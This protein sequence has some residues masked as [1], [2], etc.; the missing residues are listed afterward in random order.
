MMINM[1]PER[2]RQVLRSRSSLFALL[3]FLGVLP[4]LM[5]PMLL[6]DPQATRNPA[7]IL[8]ALCIGTFP[9]S[10]FISVLVSWP[11]YRHERYAA[12]TWV[13]ILPVANLLL[14]GMVVG[15]WKFV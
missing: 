13:S 15:L 8:L 9:L 6:D 2:T 5:S 10:C 3:G 11:L 7:I 1:D 14:G 4:A 12:A